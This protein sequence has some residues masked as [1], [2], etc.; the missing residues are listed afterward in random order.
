MTQLLIKNATVV[1]PSDG[2]NEQLDILVSDGKIAE[3]GKKLV[4]QKYSVSA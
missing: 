4:R 1:S 2:L 3:I